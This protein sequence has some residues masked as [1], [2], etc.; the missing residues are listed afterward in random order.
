[1]NGVRSRLTP[2]Q[3]AFLNASG[4]IGLDAFEELHDVFF[5]V[6]DCARRF[7]YVNTAFMT[8][9]GLTS[10]QILGRRDEDLSPEYL[11]EH[12]RQD[13]E[14]V[15]KRGERLVGVVELVHNVDGCFDWFTTTKFPI[16]NVDGQ[17]IGV[18]GITRSLTKK[19][20]VEERLLPLKPAIQLI[21]E[22][23]DQR[24]TLAE[25][26]RQCFMSPTQF[27]RLF[28]AQFGA[29]PHSYLLRVRLQAT[30]DL[31]STTKLAIGDIATRVGYYDQS[32][33]TRDLVKNKGATP[34]EYRRRYSLIKDLPVI[35]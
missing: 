4:D 6:K 15:I 29:S 35:P 20:I 34:T 14:A 21:T 18:T 11:T 13:D 28:R 19:V 22:H 24:P 9:M 23:Y 17:V 26:A 31:L 3:Q 10:D 32:H 8:L 33:L 2:A 7:V 16:R 12:Y 30:C 1:M 25:M 5:F 27:A